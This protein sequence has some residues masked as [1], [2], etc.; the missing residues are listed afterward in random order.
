ML[1]YIFSLGQA[2]LG[3]ILPRSNVA[4]PSIDTFL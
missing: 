1:E 2:T 4:L 3:E